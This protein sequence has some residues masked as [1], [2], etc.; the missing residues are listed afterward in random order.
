MQQ[1]L[2]NSNEMGKT[3]YIYVKYPLLKQWFYYFQLLIA[4]NCI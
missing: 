2:I 1:H 4:S 3:V